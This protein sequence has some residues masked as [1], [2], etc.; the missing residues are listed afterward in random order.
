M[1]CADSAN[2]L[3][4][5]LQDLDALALLLPHA[6]GMCNPEAFGKSLRKQRQV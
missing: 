3:S 4:R 6:S 2:G 5:I 1:P